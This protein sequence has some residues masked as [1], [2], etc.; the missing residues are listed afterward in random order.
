MSHFQNVFIQRGKTLEGEDLNGFGKLKNN[1]KSNKKIYKSP[2]LE[3]SNINK[4]LNQSFNTNETH[5]PKQRQSL[6]KVAL[7]IQNFISKVLVDNSNDTKYFDVNEELEE[8]KKA[9]VKT[10]NHKD[11]YHI[12]EGDENINKYLNITFDNDKKN[13]FHSTKQ[14]GLGFFKK[15]DA[16]RKNYNKNKMIRTMTDDNLKKFTHHDNSFS[17]THKFLTSNKHNSSQSNEIILD[18]FN[19]LNKDYSSQLRKTSYEEKM[20]KDKNLIND[21][22]RISNEGIKS[23]INNNSSSL[24]LSLNTLRSIIENGV[25]NKKNSNDNNSK[26]KINENN[27]QKHNN[28]YDK[29]LQNK[30]KTYENNI[31]NNLHLKLSNNENNSQKKVNPLAIKKEKKNEIP[32]FFNRRKNKERSQMINKWLIYSRIMAI[33]NPKSN[34]DLVKFSR[35]NSTRKVFQ[36][37][38]PI[39][40][41]RLQKQLKIKESDLNNKKKSSSK[42]NLTKYNDNDNLRPKLSKHFSRSKF[43]KYTKNNKSNYEKIIHP[44]KSKTSLD[45]EKNNVESLLN[46]ESLKQNILKP[47]Y[48]SIP[49]DTNLSIIEHKSY[50]EEG[51]KESNIGSIN[52]DVENIKET[53]YRRMMR[54]NKLVYDSLSDE[55]SDEILE[56]NEYISPNSQF[57]YYFDLTIFT[58]AFYTFCVNPIFLC[59]YPKHNFPFIYWYN[60]INI[61]IDLVYISDLI[62][63][64]FTAYYDIE[65][66]YIKRLSEITINYLSSWF[67][68]DLLS[69]IPFT[70]IY[71]LNFVN[72]KNNYTYSGDYELYELFEIFRLFK[73]YKAIYNNEFFH[74]LLK[75]MNKG[76]ELEKYFILIFYSLI[77]IL[78]GHLLACINIFLSNLDYPNW[79]T[80]QN[81]NNSPKT[82]IYIA[83][84]YYI[85]STVTTVGYGDIV[86]INIYER[87]N[88]L[89]LLVVGIMVY[90]YC[91]SSLSNYVQQ[92]DSKTLD[93][94]EKSRTLEQ[95]RLNHEKMPQELYEK[96]SRFLKYKLTN[97]SKVQNE[98]IDNLPIGL[99]STLI[100]EMYKPVIDNFIFFKTFNSSDFII[101]VIMAFRPILSLKNEKLINEGDYIEE[102]VFVKKGALALEL[103]L[104]IYVSDKEIEGYLTRKSTGNYT[105]FEFNRQPSR[106][107]FS[108][109]RPI[110]INF[111]DRRKSTLT[112][113]KGKGMTKVTNNTN[114]NDTNIKHVQQY[115]K[116]IEIRKNE[117][118]GDILMFLNKRS[119]LSMKVK[120]KYAELF[121]LNK[122]DAVEISMSF[123]K[124]WGQ[125]IKKSLFNME[126]IERLINKTLKFFY[127]Q[128]DRAKRRS[129]YLR[130]LNNNNTF[131][132]TD[133]Y[134]NLNEKDYELQ[135]IP[136]SSI[137]NLSSHTEKNSLQIISSEDSSSNYSESDSNSFYSS[138]NMSSISKNRKLSNISLNNKNDNN[139]NLNLDLK[140]QNKRFLNRGNETIKKEISDEENDTIIKN[141]IIKKKSSRNNKSNNKDTN[142]DTLIDKV[143]EKEEEDSSNKHVIF[144]S[145]SSSKNS[146]SKKTMKETEEYNLIDFNS[147]S[148]RNNTIVYPYTKSEIN[149]EE[150]PFENNISAIENNNNIIHSIVPKIYDIFGKPENLFVKK[151]SKETNFTT[152]SFSIN[153]SCTKNNNSIPLLIISHE[154]EF[155][156][157]RNESFV[158][159]SHRN[160]IPYKKY[161]SLNVNNNFENNFNKKQDK[162]STDEEKELQRLKMDFLRKENKGINKTFKE[163]SKSRRFSKMII[164]SDSQFNNNNEKTKENPKMRTSIFPSNK[165]IETSKETLSLIGKNIE[166]NSLALNNPKM[167]Y[168]NYF[169]NVVQKTSQRKSVVI[170]LKDL[171][172]IIKH[173]NP[174]NNMNS[175]RNSVG[176]I[177]ANIK[178]EK[179]YRH[180]SIEIRDFNNKKDET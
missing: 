27:T 75:S 110:V 51:K 111:S 79:V 6:K 159:N 166:S 28:S 165:L 15:N 154:K 30:I 25:Q 85:F 103:P 177:N 131:V 9:K 8:I 142:K 54:T 84:F 67:T 61:F 105:T 149:K 71:T 130:D 112:F 18:P 90:S 113:I 109:E 62:L 48:K 86:S 146:E 104:P 155:V 136:T 126:Q 160:H 107:L 20:K 115:V 73:I 179:K 32:L 29:N 23:K 119:P 65:E 4:L 102:I 93:Y 69:S 120:T 168:Q 158:I 76:N 178:P 11:F 55:E 12:N 88:N 172:K 141:S 82:D 169:S 80:V 91:V 144:S 151:F 139:T 45:N 170:R 21:I 116:I 156:I 42:S 140:N 3:K 125:I 17:S 134:A 1:R 46:V 44:K 123:P 35:K 40:S 138:S 97:E 22:S 5:S 157:V 47:E 148:S 143:S 171:E 49:M 74:Y 56:E 175:N 92:V 57:K 89:I 129:Y 133:Y 95:I 135:S 100:M 150:L 124:I 164:E 2:T 118:F 68:I 98:L 36:T 41:K 137:E 78:H 70:T 43:R 59:F 64:F 10:L 121:L 31:N 174:I 147:F 167:F 52:F 77:V 60:F 122:T 16:N 161:K 94:Q 87:F 58:F 19:P 81:L 163:K 39:S 108:N 72:N 162:K 173:N 117:H 66:R 14:I 63:G 101:K 37:I 50:L 127:I 26:E 176:I 114:N 132:N 96:I 33:S 83:S 152:S 180:A 153:I 38:N 53:R 145:S 99:R 7:G 13:N 34:E 24:K 128:N 106:K